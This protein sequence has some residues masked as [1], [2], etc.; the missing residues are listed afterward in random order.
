[1]TEIRKRF[2]IPRLRRLVKGIRYHCYGCKRFHASSFSNP[3]PGNLPVDR[4]EG[5]KA[6]QVVGVD[7]AGAITYL[8]QKTKGAKSYILLFACSLS[9]AVYLEL[10]TNQT[11]DSFIR[12]LKRFISRRGRPE[13]IYS[14][15]AKSFKKSA[16]WLNTIMKSEKLNDF[17]AHKDIKWQFNRA[18]WWGGQFERIIGLV[19]Q[20]LYKTIGNS[21]LK[22]NELEEVLL[23]VEETLNNRPLSYVEDDIQLPVLTPNSLIFG[24]SPNVIPPEDDSRLVEKGDLRKRFKYV[25][26]CK[27][28]AWSRWSQ[29]YLKGLRERH[30][31][32]H[33]VMKSEPK[34]GDIVMVKGE[35]KN[36]GSWKLGVVI[37]IFPGSDGVIRAV[38]LRCDNGSTLQRPVQLLYPLELS[39]DIEKPVDE[40]P[41]N[42][43]AREFRPRRNAAEIAKIRISDQFAGM[44]CI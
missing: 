41:L 27:N 14:D 11:S 36:R 31:L 43:E 32:K 19:K 30:N 40:G 4:S 8:K 42:A 23:D 3:P 7:F 6:F 17:L 26:K 39:C 38:E 44:E 16:K 10:L 1:M 21:T 37:N 33:K 9:R 34:I 35:N 12:C 25:M 2:W 22:F 5:T 18:P 29:E 24:E 13:K 28:N 15:N 20:S